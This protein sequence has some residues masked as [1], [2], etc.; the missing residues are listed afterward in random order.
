MTLT[1]D[2]LRDLKRPFAAQHHEFL[3]GNVYLQERAIC[4]RLEQ[5][6]PG[7]QFQHVQT[8]YTNNQVTVVMAMTVCGVT[9]TNAGTWDIQYYDPDD[10]KYASKTE[11]QMATPHNQAEK[12]ATTDAL[13]RCARLF[14][15]GRYLL[16]CPKSVSDERS[17]QRWLGDTA[18]SSQTTDKA[19]PAPQQT[20]S[21]VD[22]Q[23]GQDAPQAGNGDES[24][25]VTVTIE[26]A[27]KIKTKKGSHMVILTT[28][29]GHTA[30]MFSAQPLRDAGYADADELTSEQSP[31]LTW[32]EG[33][34]PQA[35][36]YRKGDYW[37]VKRVIPLLE[38]QFPREQQ[39]MPGVPPVPEGDVDF[40]ADSM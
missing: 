26:K 25:T 39:A 3:R 9:R 1:H 23:T 14:G 28:E 13:K 35:E 36:I 8:T 7:W 21:G 32:V 12:N 22:S 40:Y 29:S 11:R 24:E 27:K 20:D 33:S 5:V 38:T 16:D 34:R 6:D 15:V 37:N 4:E 19:K 17:L 10:K 2:D 31:P 18:P 30:S